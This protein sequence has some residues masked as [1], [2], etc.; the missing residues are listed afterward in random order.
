MRQIKT[1]GVFIHIGLI[2]NSDFCP[3]ELKRNA[4]GEIIVDKI[5][6]TSMPGVF[7]AGDVTDTP[8]KQIGVAVG[9]GIAAALSCFDYLNKH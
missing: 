5:M 1:D 7:A 3:P 9:Q 8:Y 2:P 4:R 6:A